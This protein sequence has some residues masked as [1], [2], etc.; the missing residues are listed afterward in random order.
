VFL[1]SQFLEVEAAFS[2]D[3]RWLAYQSNESGRFEVHVR[4]FPGPGGKWQVST[5]GGLDPTWS[6]NRKELFYQTL[7]STLMVAPYAVEGDSFRAEKPR[8]WSPG[9]VPTRGVNR[10]FDLHPA[11]QR[12][13][14]LK[15]SE[16]QAEEKRDHV[17][18][19][20]NFFDEL[21]R[22]APAAKQ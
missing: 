7:E 9:L 5:G 12:L 1:N 8:Q 2:P 15:A 14:V 17:V 10:T 4:P 11:G 3:G 16:Q 19:I 22:V 21:R 13:A 18:F 20:E 6:R